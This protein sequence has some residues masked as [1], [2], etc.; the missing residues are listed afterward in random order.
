MVPV[1][2]LI[3]LAG[4][5]WFT[6]IGAHTPYWALLVALFPDRGRHGRHHHPAM[7]AAY[8]GLHPPQCSPQCCHGGRPLAPPASCPPGGL[9]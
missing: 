1:G 9:T 6:Q 7:A 8:Q 3:P 2:V 5:A 4:T